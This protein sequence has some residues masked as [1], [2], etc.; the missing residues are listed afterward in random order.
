MLVLWFINNAF[1]VGSVGAL[2]ET[3]T[4]NYSMLYKNS[5]N[6]IELCWYINSHFFIAV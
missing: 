3:E 1:C 4:T 6:N 2:F 5:V